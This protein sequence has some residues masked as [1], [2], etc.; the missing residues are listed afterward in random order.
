MTTQ[1]RLLSLKFERFFD[2]RQRHVDDRGVEDDD[3]LRR[4]EQD[5]RDPAL[6][7]GGGDIGHENLLRG[8]SI[9][10]PVDEGVDLLVVEGDE[11]GDL[12]QLGGRE[13]VRPGEVLVDRVADL[14]R[15]VAGRRPLVGTGGDG[16]GGDEVREVDR[17]PI[18]VA[19][20]RQPGLEE[21]DRRAALGEDD[22]LE[23]DP[24]LPRRAQRVD[25]GVGAAGMDEDPLVLLVPGLE[26]LPLDPH[27]PGG[28]DLVTLF[29]HAGRR[30]EL[31]ERR[32]VDVLVRHVVLR[33][34]RVLPDVEGALRIE[35]RAPVE[36][37]AQAP[38]R[39]LDVARADGAARVAGRI[40]D[41]DWG[42]HLRDPSQGN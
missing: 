17:R 36:D 1:G 24:Q 39:G 35:H 3:E 31:L 30:A 6:V 40:R 19:A 37:T 18:E 22:A 16:V 20:G 4:A 29:D 10:T 2:R 15:P 8:R 38:R 41:R 5:Q 34:V 21:E 12:G 27:R 11:A 9:W 23:L 14:H 42:R 33:V 13:L 26:R 32:R 28:A 25:P 7:A